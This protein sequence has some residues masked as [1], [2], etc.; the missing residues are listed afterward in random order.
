MRI[1]N[2]AATANPIHF[3]GFIC[4]AFLGGNVEPQVL[5]KPGTTRTIVEERKPAVS[6]MISRGKI[7]SSGFLSCFYLVR[8]GVRGGVTPLVPI[9]G[10][11][12]ERRRD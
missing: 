1:S 9:F 2:P 12:V 3:H 11:R 6:R 4:G 8:D 5:Q 7:V 10:K